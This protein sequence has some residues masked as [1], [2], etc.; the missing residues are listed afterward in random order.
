MK[1]ANMKINA[2]ELVQKK[3]LSHGVSFK[4]ETQNK[5]SSKAFKALDN[6]NRGYIFKDELLNHIKASGTY[7][8]HQLSYLVETL[9]KMAP[10]EPITSKT[11]EELIHATNFIKI[12]LENNLAIPQFSGFE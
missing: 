8:N 7:T 10:R 1:A 6:D 2:I 3:S 9:E 5:W 12:V 11:F 4:E